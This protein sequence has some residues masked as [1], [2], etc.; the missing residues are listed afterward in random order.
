MQSQKFGYDGGYRQNS[1][2]DG[3]DF[4]SIDHP[5]SEVHAVH[6]GKVTAKAWG[7]G[8]INWYVVITDDGG[9][10]VEYQEAF[11]S[12]SNITVNV[13]DTVKTGQVIGYRTTDHLHIGITKMSI[14][15]AFSHAFK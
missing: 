1:F 7:S 3:L 8:G 5:G 11:G 12:E 15:A 6:G 4:G 9:L 13:G 10:N 14:P 2:H